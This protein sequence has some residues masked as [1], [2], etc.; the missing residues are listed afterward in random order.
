VTIEGVQIVPLRQI[1]DDRGKV[2]H[3]LRADAPHFRA[4]GEIYFSVVNPGCIKAWHRHKI[5]TL[6]YAVPVGKIKFVL[7]DNRPDSASQGQVQEILLGPD[8]YKLVVVPPLLWSGFE[9]LG[10]EPSLVANCASIPHDPQEIERT[11]PFDPSIP[12][13]WDL[14]RT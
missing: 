5:M 10:T 8:D 7:Y 14:R 12:Y 1:P 4:F 3:M 11:D 6:N 9:G 13:D 2:M